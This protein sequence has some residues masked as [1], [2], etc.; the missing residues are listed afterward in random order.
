M[1]R[2]LQAGTMSLLWERGQMCLVQG[3]HRPVAPL[4][5]HQEAVVPRAAVKPVAVRRA[6]RAPVM[7]LIMRRVRARMVR[8]MERGRPRR[9]IAPD[10]M[11]APPPPAPA[12]QP[13]LLMLVQQVPEAPERRRHLLVVEPAALQIR[14]P[15]ILFRLVPS[16]ERQ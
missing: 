15:V 10:P 9:R 3:R 14:M 1:V 12:R 11:L 4:A 6:G 2:A 16:P 7:A 13:L 8:L 5:V